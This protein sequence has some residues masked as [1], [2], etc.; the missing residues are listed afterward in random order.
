MPDSVHPALEDYDE[1]AQS[2]NLGRVTAALRKP[3]RRHIALEF[4]D[5]DRLPGHDLARR[6]GAQ[7]RL[8]Q[9]VD[10]ERVVHPRKYVE[11]TAP[12][13]GHEMGFLHGNLKPENVL[14]GHVSRCPGKTGDI[15]DR[16]GGCPCS[17]GD[18]H[19]RGDE[20]ALGGDA[21]LLG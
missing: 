8:R 9:G 20:A 16:D 11:G 21:G 7:A 18:G 19:G 10:S 13:W 3:T 5:H 4:L 2:A 6:L 1:L 12:R 15:G 14:L 17:V